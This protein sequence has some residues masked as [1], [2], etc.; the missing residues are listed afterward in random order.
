[1]DGLNQCNGAFLLASIED[2]RQLGNLHS[3]QVEALALDQTAHTPDAV[4]SMCLGLKL[5]ILL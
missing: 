4:V 5:E 3:S 2:T 1:M